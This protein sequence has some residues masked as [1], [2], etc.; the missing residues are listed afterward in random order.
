MI[1]VG[2]ESKI[3]VDNCEKIASLEG[4]DALS[5]GISDLSYALGHHGQ[6]D[7]P[8]VQGALKTVTDVCKAKGK[9]A[10]IAGLR[11]YDAEALLRPRIP[12]F[13]RPSPTWCS[14]CATQQ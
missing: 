5:V 14:S 4:I 8:V 6:L 9:L 13:R 12:G 2:I 1:F 11:C 7:H 3:G 10:K